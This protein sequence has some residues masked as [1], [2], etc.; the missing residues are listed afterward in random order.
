MSD[1]SIT[2]RSSRTVKPSA[3]PHID[4]NNNILIIGYLLYKLNSFYSIA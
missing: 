3:K 4:I 2:T 1:A